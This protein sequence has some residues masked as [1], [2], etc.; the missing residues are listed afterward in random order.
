MQVIHHLQRGRDDPP[1]D[2]A[3]DGRA[4][5]RHGGEDHEQRLDGLGHRDQAADDAGRHSERPLRADIEAGQV[6]AGVVE[7]FATRLHDL[8]VRQHELQPE[9]VVGGDAVPQRVR[10]AGVLA[11]VP[12]NGARLLAGWV[13]DIQKLLMGDGLGESEIHQARLDDGPEILQI[14]F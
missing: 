12:A 4:G 5:C 1:A 7:R 10:P 14:D 2:D 6:V 3:A 11:D 9:R 8:A 13:G